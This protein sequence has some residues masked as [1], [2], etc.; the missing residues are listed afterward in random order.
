MRTASALVA[1]AL[2]LLASL[3]ASAASG[4]P[5]A[6]VA[7]APAPELKPFGNLFGQKPAPKKPS[8]DWNWRPSTDQNAAAKDSV[9]CGM[10]VIQAD[11]K[12]D[13]KMRVSVPD[14]RVAFTMRAVQPTICKG[15]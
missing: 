2:T 11:P 8:I 1:G 6:Q 12:V 13:P 15:P 9:V 14:R 7:V 5:A 3:P 10:T 4:H